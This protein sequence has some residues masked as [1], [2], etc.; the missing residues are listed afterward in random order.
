MKTSRLLILALLHGI[1]PLSLLADDAPP[2]RPPFPRLQALRESLA[3]TDEQVAKLKPLLE[4]EGAELKAL[5]ADTNLAEDQKRAKAREIMSAG[6]DKL[7]AILTEEQKGKWTALQAKR[8]EGARPGAGGDAEKRLA[9][10]QEKLGLSETQVAKLKPILAEEAPKL[11]AVRE[12]QTSTPEE[13]RALVKASMERI[14][15]ELTP[16]QREKMRAEFS[17]RAPR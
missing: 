15:S 11:R 17:L 5:R 10:M 16:E 13:K 2:A 14:A 4:S 7:A 1:L 8:T 12:D 6:R 9:A 3:L